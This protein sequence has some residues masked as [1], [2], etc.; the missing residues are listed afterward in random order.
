VYTIGSVGRGGASPVKLALAGAAFSAFVG[1]ITT[2][3]TLLDVSSLNEFRFWVVG[4]L[5]RADAAALGQVL[6][7]VLVGVA[8]ALGM[9]RAANA[10]ALGDDLAR[11]IGARLHVVRACGALAVVLLAGSATAIAGPIGFVGLVVP[12]IARAMVGPDYR[13]ILPWCLVLAP[14]ILLAAD[15]AGRVVLR[16]EEVQ[17][18]IMTALIGAPF[19]LYLVRKRKLAQ[20]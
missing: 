12:H 14:T 18:G 17:V 13:W 1:S 2:A 11:S 5:G 6:P 10:L 8:L 16:P 3:I 9:G 20:L 4:S 7:F 15:I 19:F